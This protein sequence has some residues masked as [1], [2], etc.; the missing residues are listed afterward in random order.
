M[1]ETTQEE[2]TNTLA[3]E[4]NLEMRVLRSCMYALG[5]LPQA[6]ARKRVL[7]W[8]NAKNNEDLMKLVPVQTQHV[9]G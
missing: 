8:V 2:E 7:D 6:V 9:N 3:D 5:K 1:D 4:T